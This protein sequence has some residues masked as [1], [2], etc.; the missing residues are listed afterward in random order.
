MSTLTEIRH[1]KPLILSLTNSVTIQRVADLVSF[2]GASPLMSSEKDEIKD[3]LT[4]AS[5]LVL[6]TGTLSQ[7]DVPL[8]IVAGRLA[9]EKESRLF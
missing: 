2:L 6:N 1:Q 4:L 5:V 8:F 3:L 9:N 7:E